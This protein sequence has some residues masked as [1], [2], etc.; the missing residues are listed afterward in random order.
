[1]T[2]ISYLD[3][4][5]FFNAI[6][7]GAQTLFGEREDLNR[8][9]VF[10]VPDGDTGNNLTATVASIIEGTTV[11]PSL[12]V[13]A[14]SIAD[15]A[16]VGA[17]G[18]S[19]LILAQYFY[20][21][22]QEIGG[23]DRIETRSLGDL[24]SGAV[25]YARDAIS[26][27]VDGTVLTVIEEWSS[28][29]RGLQEKYSD[30]ADLLPASLEAARTSL[31]STTSRLKALRDANVV[32]AAG[33][34]F[35]ALLEGISDFIRRGH[36]RNVA[37]VMSTP[38][39]IMEEHSVRQGE[40]TNRYCTEAILSS[41]GLDLPGLRKQLESF[42][43]SVIVSGHDR[44]IHFHL[45]T[46]QPAE[47]FHELDPI[48][49]FHQPKIDDMIRQ[50]EAGREVKPRIALV[51]DTTSDLP[52]EILDRYNI[53]MVPVQLSFGD[54]QYLDR[55]SIT[56]DIF[57][58]KLAHTTE[59]PTSSQ[60]PVSAFES[61]YSFL[62]E[63]YDSIISIN[64]SGGL[65]GTRDAALTAADRITSV[66]VTIIDSRTLTAGLGL[67]VLEAA[68]AIE[69]G[70][71][72]EEVVDLVNDT[73]P[74][75]RVLVGAR[76]L[77]FF[78]R[79]GR[80]SPVQGLVGGLLNVKPIIT[81]GRDGKGDTFGRAFSQRGTLR[82]IE[83]ELETIIQSAGIRRYAVVHSS[84]AGDAAVW[85]EKLTAITGMPPT[86]TIDISPVIGV[87][88][89]PGALGICLLEGEPVRV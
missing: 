6:A 25:R 29:V 66:P 23:R 10:P 11:H 73:I 59:S 45:H 54:S 30:L 1:M 39:E 89:G 71:S 22:S 18:N 63:H 38:R 87:H 60:P 8:I 47:L 68:E 24:F 33:K 79:G 77:K 44:K 85:A 56:P 42:G 32:D 69:Q 57:Y 65:S 75:S 88:A 43:D 37:E 49:S 84:R 50:V 27:P 83:K 67:I 12:Q 61:L 78:I 76:T 20:G 19:G 72:H 3:G 52:P 9:N 26:N 70:R 41:E 34:G 62:A 53:H 31:Q 40:V 35:V 80:I 86:Y 58:R 48:G 81:V 16:L 7:A 13:T 17:R 55:F 28:A 64:L 4:P 5:R 14:D 36:L 2:K 15:T 51:T 74:L 46:N 21:I 82:N